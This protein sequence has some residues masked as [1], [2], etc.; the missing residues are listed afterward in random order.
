MELCV[1]IPGAEE[2]IAFLNSGFTTSLFGALL[3]AWAGAWAAQRITERIKDKEQLVGQIRAANSAIMS[4]FVICNV[5]L[6]LKKQHTQGLYNNFCKQK[7]AL[8]HHHAGLATGTIAAGTPF[9]F[10]A[11]FRSLPMPLVPIDT[12]KVQAYEKLSING[13][14]LALVSS[15]VGALD[16]LR[17][18]MHLRNELIDRFKNL[19]PA[20]M[21]L[22]PALYFGLPYGGGHV[23][24]EYSDSVNAIRL[25]TDDV[26]FFGHLLCKDLEEY[27]NQVS[28]EYESRFRKK[29]I[30]VNSANFDI[31]TAENLL[32]DEKDYADWLRAFLVPS[33][34][35]AAK[36]T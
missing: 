13:R 8:Q 27:G 6:S 36:S 11:D 33:Q 31:A 3:G 22:L 21:A 10:Q 9:E 32:P 29:T 19:S 26:I 35:D 28:N 17:S 2:I 7:E 5:I 25:Y 24:T 20:E 30:K 18:S 16:S 23:S 34:A 1:Y 4:A 15:L 12:L 14:P